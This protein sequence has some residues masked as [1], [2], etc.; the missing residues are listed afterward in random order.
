MAFAGKLK[1]DHNVESLLR[2]DEGGSIAEDGIAKIRIE[3]A[4]VTEGRDFA[5]D[6]RISVD[7][8]EF[9]PVFLFFENP[10][11][12]G[13]RN[14]ALAQGRFERIKIAFEETS[15]FSEDDEA[16]AQ[17]GGKHGGAEEGARAFG[18]PQQKI[19]CVVG[20]EARTFG[21]CIGGESEGLAE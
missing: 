1:G 16:R 5:G 11:G 21:A 19:E 12:P 3:V 6:R 7:A 17:R 15:I 9:A 13:G 2:R 14:V 4:P 10:G 18:V 8:G 20:R